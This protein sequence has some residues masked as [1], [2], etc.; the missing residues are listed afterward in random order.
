MAAADTSDPGP[1]MTMGR[2][3]S[4]SVM[5][6]LQ[7][8]IWG[9]WFV[10]LGV[11]LERGLKFEPSWIGWAYSTMALGTMVTPL[12]IG[13]VAD[14]YFDSEK[15][16]AVLHLLGAGV[17]YL[18]AQITDPPAFV[19]VALVYALVYSP[20]LVLS[21]SITFAH[22]PHSS[23]FAWVRVWGT[24]GWIVVNLVVIGWLM[25]KFVAD[26]DQT[27]KPLLLAAGCSAA[28]GLFS[29]F[30]PHTP[31]SGKPGDAFP[32]GKAL[33]LLREPSFAVFFG[34]SFVI[35]IVLAF[36]YGFTGNYFKD[37]IL[38]KLPDNIDPATKAFKLDWAPLSTL[39][40]FS[41]MLL[42]PLLP[43]VLRGIGMKWVLALG[44]FAWGAR[45]YAFSMGARGTLDPWM[46]VASLAFHGV[47]FDF[48]FAAGFIHVENEAPR[49]IR[50]SAQALFTFLTYGL[51]M[52]IGNVLSGYIVDYYSTGP[53]TAPV[54]DWGSIWVVPSVGVF[55]S[56]IIFVLFFRTRRQPAAA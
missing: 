10:V 38:P 12:I 45:Y 4:L 29:F 35:T 43:F 11:Y 46:V 27:N 31:P 21:N 41:E 17:L 8:A 53:N 16:M 1:S 36:Y 48:F 47:C 5:M 6:F 44:M 7:F 32:A 19:A 34:V 20:T 26:V 49:D 39:G 15:M 25:P 13:P 18:M 23:W 2:Y 37:A 50:A 24:I 51:G 42:L 56:L 40:Q 54:R 55:V 14:R 33:G 22:V 3:A 30:L 52:F 28:L 9:S